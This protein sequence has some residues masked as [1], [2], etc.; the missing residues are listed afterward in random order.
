MS[1]KMDQAFAY[2][3]DETGTVEPPE[4][5]KV[6]GVWTPMEPALE[7]YFRDAL[8]QMQVIEGEYDKIYFY[9]LDTKELGGMNRP[10]SGA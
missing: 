8:V 1:E 3:G 9:E 6:T 2:W 10:C 4:P 5:V 7:R